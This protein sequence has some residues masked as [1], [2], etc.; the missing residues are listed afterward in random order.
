MGSRNDGAS[1]NAPV[2][3]IGG[4][5]PITQQFDLQGD[6]KVFAAIFSVIT[7]FNINKEI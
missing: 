5:S 2:H 6:Q 1:A 7:L 3:S 4:R